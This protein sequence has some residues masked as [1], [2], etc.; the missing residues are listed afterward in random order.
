MESHFHKVPRCDNLDQLQT[1]TQWGPVFETFLTSLAECT[2]GFDA[3]AA[4]HF[5]QQ[6]VPLGISLPKFVPA[7]NTLWPSASGVAK[8]IGEPLALPN[9][10]VVYLTVIKESGLNKAWGSF[11]SIPCQ[12]MTPVSVSC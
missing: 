4:P 3:N 11:M 6:N 10:S 7:A 8:L 9:F 1:V 12:P 5:A 2:A